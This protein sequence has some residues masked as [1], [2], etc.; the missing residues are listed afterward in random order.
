MEER[1]H[2]R[3]KPPPK[4]VHVFLHVAFCLDCILIV[5]SIAVKLA[6]GGRGHDDP[7]GVFVFDDIKG[8]R[9]SFTERRRGPIVRR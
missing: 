5:Q 3:E 6:N 4:R 2:L 8:E 9:E 1:R 7:S